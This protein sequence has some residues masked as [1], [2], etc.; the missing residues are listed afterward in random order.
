[1]EYEHGAENQPMDGNPSMR[2]PSESAMHIARADCPE[3]D[4]MA[5]PQIRL[6]F[7]VN[8]GT[9]VVAVDASKNMSL[10]STTLASGNTCPIMIASA[11]TGNPMASVLAASAGFS[12]S[13]GAV[14]NALEPTIDGTY[15]PFTTAR[16]YVPFVHL[17]NP[18][19]IISK[20]VK[21]FNAA[22]DLQ[23]SA[24][25]E[26]AKY[27][28]VLPFAEQTSSFA[29]AAVQEFQSPFDSAPWT[30]QPGS[31]IRNFNVGIGS[32]QVIDISHD[33][34][35]H[36]FTNE[37]AK[38]GAINGDLTPEL[39]NGLLNYQAWS[40]S[41]RMLIADVSRL[42]EKDIPQSIQIQGTNAGCQGVNLLV[43][44]ISEQELTL[45]RLTGEVLE[46]S[47]ASEKR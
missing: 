20:P 41:N 47:T 16:L 36:H 38:I 30:L 21:K 37:I 19:A 4:L 12:V 29:T 5:N 28:V 18:Q 6:R 35:F 17:E 1:M 46:F 42:P 27:V 8:Q 43:L 33:Y 10:T 24:S 14:V 45:D 39:V 2:G 23:L 26:N 22:F 9:S 34:D 44:V 40:L 32:S 31:S 11:A 3:L 7:R 13:W 15:M 25:V